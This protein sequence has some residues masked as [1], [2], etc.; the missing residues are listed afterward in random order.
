MS[1]SLAT[2]L[3]VYDAKVTSSGLS[4]KVGPLYSTFALY[5]ITTWSVGVLIFVKKWRSSRGLA[6]AQ[7]HYLGAGI[8]G[9]SLGGIFTNLLVPLL[10]GDSR[11]SW[12]GPY[13]SLVYVGFIAHAIIRL[14]L[15]DLRL[16]VHRG[17]TITIMPV[18]LLSD[19]AGSATS[20]NRALATRLL[21]DLDSVE[22]VLFH[23]LRIGVVSPSLTAIARC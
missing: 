6:R 13:F 22:L 1:L 5:F 17:L 11:Y 4:R 15:M 10:T 14:R 8:I 7:F 12:I 20:C 21:M 23:L 18:V 19:Y 9:G 3:V 2:D 16:F